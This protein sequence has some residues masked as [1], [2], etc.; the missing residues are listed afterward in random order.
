MSLK[1]SQLLVP[2][3]SFEK[4]QLIRKSVKG[5]HFGKPLANFCDYSPISRQ[6]STASEFRKPHGLANL[7]YRQ[8]L[9]LK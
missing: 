9:P 7:A 6:Y 2:K 1:G 4:Q 8:P 3:T 5:T